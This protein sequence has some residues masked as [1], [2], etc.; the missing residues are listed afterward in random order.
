MKLSKAQ[1]IRDNPL[2]ERPGFYRNMSGPFQNRLRGGRSGKSS[3]FKKVRTYTFSVPLVFD[4]FSGANI[5]SYT[6]EHKL[7]FVPYV[8]GTIDQGDDAYFPF[9]FGN[10]PVYARVGTLTNKTVTL[11]FAMEFATSLRLTIYLMQ[12]P[13]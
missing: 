5:G 6:V 2:N 7:G 10:G 13:V 4:A 1:T 12:P 11:S 8:V 9:P 3:L